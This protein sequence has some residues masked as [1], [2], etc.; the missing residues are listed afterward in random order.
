MR[1][2]AEPLLGLSNSPGTP[3]TTTTER[4]HDRKKARR[5][6]FNG[7]YVGVIVCTSTTALV[8]VI[9]IGLTVWAS[10]KNGLS[11]GL[12]TIQD[13]SCQQT[14]HLSLWLHLA[15]NT[16][17]TALLAASNYC[18]QCLSSPTRKEV[19]QAHSH[20]TW[21]DIGVPSVRNL[22]RI[23]RKRVILWWL[24]AFSGI[25]LHLL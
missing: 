9:N 16:L 18:M 24:L 21:L 22:R 6:A 15:I 5:F 3:S 14:K 12:A 1:S 11:N 8:L 17:S 4:C 25:P 10:A 19:D 13:G 7:W 23:A 2:G 20:Y